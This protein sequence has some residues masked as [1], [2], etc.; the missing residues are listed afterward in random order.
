MVSNSAGTTFDVELSSQFLQETRNIVIYLPPNYSPLFSYPV[1]YVQDGS[2]YITF[3]KIIQLLEEKMQTEQWP[4]F[5][6]VA[7]PV[8]R[9]NRTNEYHLQGEKHSKYL[10]FFA[11]ELIPY[12]DKHYA[13]ETLGSARAIIGDSL[14]A[15]VALSI[16]LEYPY[17]VENVISQ[18]GFFDPYLLE[19][20]EAYQKNPIIHTYL[21][22]GTEE[23]KVITKRYGEFNILEW[24]QKAYEVLKKHPLFQVEYHEE[25]GDHT[26]GFWQEHLAE[27]IEF[28]LAKQGIRSK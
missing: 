17:S 5:I 18:S 11:E 8:E 23:T 27:G 13:T 4:P 1:L 12:I 3:G 14:A 7:I 25:K 24:N 2:D 21:I 20:M 19:K 10:R 16:S 22:V 15:H 28:F 6:M 9:N 26:W